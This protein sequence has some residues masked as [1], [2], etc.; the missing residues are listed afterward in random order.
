LLSG[1]EGRI[2][3]GCELSPKLIKLLI[4]SCLPFD[5]RKILMIFLIEG[6][7]G[8]K[9]KGAGIEV[10]KSYKNMWPSGKSRL[11]GKLV[12]V[13]FHIFYFR[14]NYFN[15]CIY[16]YYIFPDEYSY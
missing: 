12:Y 4:L 2:Q 1:W 11:K 6:K 5:Q 13:V 8:D 10:I 3:S 14:Y 9:I 7:A 16:F 15:F